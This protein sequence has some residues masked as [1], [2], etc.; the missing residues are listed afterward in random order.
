MPLLRNKI[1]KKQNI[2]VSEQ[3]QNPI[4]K[5]VERDKV[6]TSNTQMQCRSLSW[7]GTCT[8]ILSG[9]V[10]LATKEFNF[11]RYNRYL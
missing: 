4:S 9:G 8:S 3:L 1:K 5:L 6:N 2:L 11:Y 7:I 10:K